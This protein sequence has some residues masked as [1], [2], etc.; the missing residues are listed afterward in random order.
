MAWRFKRPK[1]AH[2]A[3]YCG[4]CARALRDH[5]TE[6]IKREIWPY[7]PEEAIVTLKCDQGIVVDMYR[8]A[9]LLFGKAS[10]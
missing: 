2:Y 3:H 6:A 5:K 8:Q 1:N 4:E 10:K 7:L 9:C